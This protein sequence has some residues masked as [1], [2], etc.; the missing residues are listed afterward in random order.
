MMLI[1]SSLRGAGERS[2]EALVRLA[3]DAGFGGIALGPFCARAD[4][5]E[6][7]AGAAAAGL[8]VPVTATPF[9]DTAALPPGKRL[10]FFASVDD[11]EER[12]A[13]VTLFGRTLDAAVPLGVRVFTVY[14]G[15]VP[16]GV[17]AVEIRRRFQ[18][19]ELDEDEPGAAPLAD[20]FAERRA[21]SP[22]ILDACRFSLDLLAPLAERACVSVALEV[23]GGPWG[24]PTPREATVLLEEYR[25][26]P[27]GVVWD[28]ARLHVLA[29]LGAAPIEER[30][31]LLAAAARVRR[32]NEAVGIDVGFLPGQGDSP[33]PALADISPAPGIPTVVAGRGDSTVDELRRARALAAPAE[34][35]QPVSAESAR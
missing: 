20:A 35:K 10:P 30:A 1:A 15:D 17:S 26:A 5:I 34:P 6:L 2:A 18:R 27:F 19:R 11:P 21:R 9:L 3:G 22:Q 16:L 29:T 14:L 25:E 23:S 8:A 4:A 13:A 28:D 7:V 33:L 31:R 24:A 32:A 12:R